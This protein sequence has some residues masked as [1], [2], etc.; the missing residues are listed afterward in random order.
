MRTA[1]IIIVVTFLTACSRTP[2]AIDRLVADLT[3][4]GGMWLNGYQGVVH[5][6][7]FASKRQILT[8]CFKS[9][10]FTI[11]AQGV[12]V[13][14][15]VTRFKILKVRQVH[16]PCGSFQPDDY[17]AVLAHTDFGDKIV[18]L[19][20]GDG[21][22]WRAFDADGHYGRI[23]LPPLQKAAAEMNFKAVE[24]LLNQKADANAKTFDGMTAMHFAAMS[25]QTNIMQLLFDHQAKVNVTTINAGWT[26]LHFAAECG[27]KDAVQLLLLNNADINAKAR[28]GGETPLHIALKRGHTNVVEL[29]RQ[30]GGHE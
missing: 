22:W 2:D 17:A 14:G 18:L 21:W 16:I 1:F 5:L 13:T 10:E 26:P 12:K 28:Y 24:S 4:T 9:V 8:E 27:Q 29:L 19:R 20:P 30:Y 6:S 15:Y 3:S 7:K 11:T 25:G 23:E